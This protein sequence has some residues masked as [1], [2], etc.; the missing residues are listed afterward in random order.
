MNGFLDMAAIRSALA[1]RAPEVAVALLGEPNRAISNRCDLRFGRKGSVSVVIAGSKAGL[2][3]DHELGVGGD[4]LDLIQREHGG[5]F[6]AAIRFSKNFIGSRPLASRPTPRAAPIANDPNHNQQHAME[7]WIGAKPIIDSPAAIYLAK[8]QVLAAA[9]SSDG[10]TLRF[11]PACPF[12]EGTYPCLIALMRDAITNE[13]RA[14]QRTAL[15]HDGCKIG[16]KM[17]GPKK[18]AV[19]KIAG[20]ETITM[21]L[22]IG[23][24][25]ETVLSAMTLLH[26]PPAWAC[27]D[28][29]NL[30]DFPVLSGIESL[31]IIV[32]NDAGKT[33]QER[34]LECSARWTRAGREVIR[35]V[36]R[37]IFDDFNDIIQRVNQHDAV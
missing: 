35:H 37:R 10:D 36:P 19:I 6:L 31:T 11:H 23:E 13:P 21:G 28:A 4:L 17:L 9:S 18:G 25:L 12:G 33:G 27:G 3:H 24:G 1:E 34:S 29:G 20:D 7:I 2:W 14:I 32:D 8:R 5:G 15:T 16:C 30:K 22:T 26:L